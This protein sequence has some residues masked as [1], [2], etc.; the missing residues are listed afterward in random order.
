MDYVEKGGIKM[1]DYVTL[2]C[3]KCGERFDSEWNGDVVESVIVNIDKCYECGLKDG[4]DNGYDD[5]YL[6][7]YADA[8]E[9]Y[10]QKED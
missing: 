5:G 2:I 9:D 10:S 7:G 6:T 3:R 8:V 1:G 4:Y